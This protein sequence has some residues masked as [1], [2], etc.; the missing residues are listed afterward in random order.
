MP[1]DLHGPSSRELE[2]WFSGLLK[3]RYHLSGTES[4]MHTEPQV[5]KQQMEGSLRL[6][7]FFHQ[8]IISEGNNTA[9]PRCDRSTFLPS[10]SYS[11]GLHLGSLENYFVVSQHR[12]L[13]PST[14]LA[15]ESWRCTWAIVS[16]PELR[17]SSSHS[18]LSMSIILSVIYGKVANSV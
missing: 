9:H 17:I 11:F 5:P 10:S 4:R 1:Y 7:I 16:S 3:S 8:H 13:E 15:S 18:F 12:F 14:L 2:A 6:S